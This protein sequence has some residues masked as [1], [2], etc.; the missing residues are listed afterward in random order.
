MKIGIAGPLGT[1]DFEHLLSDDTAHL[2]REMKGAPLLVPLI[3]SLI[4]AGHEVVAFTTDPALEPRRGNR[5]IARGH[6]FS[7]NYVP[8][9]R[10]SLRPD[11]GARG[12]MLDFFAL[13][14]KELAEAMRDESPDLVHAH[15]SYEYGSAALQA[16]L[17]ALITCHDAPWA[18]LKLKRDLYRLGRLLMARSV[19]VRARHLTAVSPYLAE[20][21]R[22]MVRCPIQVVP[23]PVPTSL[24]DGGGPRA[25]ADWR[26]R[27]PRIVMLING[28]GPRKNAEPAMQA[29]CRILDAYPGARM[30]LYGP[31]FGAGERAQGWAAGQALPE[32]FEYHGWTPNAEVLRALAEMD[33]LVHPSLE[34]SFGMTVAEAMTLGVPVVAGQSSGAVPWVLGGSDGG[35]LLVDVRSPDAIAEA[36]LHLLDDKALYARSSARG[37][38]RASEVFSPDAV[39]RAYLACYQRVLAETGSIPSGALAENVR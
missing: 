5:V 23:N 21:L 8:L 20:E 22:A 33:I 37:R 3:E 35:G 38:A 26:D 16:G 18:I 29:M 11:R 9:R 31:D 7:V 39:A 14:R 10:H 15:W 28:W 1:G 2:P 6:R 12:R 27:P 17:P 19:L 34:E 4:A 13:E 36:V 32:V 30:H 24:I 25:P